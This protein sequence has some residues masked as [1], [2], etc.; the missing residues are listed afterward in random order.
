MKSETQRTLTISVTELSKNTSK[1]INKLPREASQINVMK[2][3]QPVAVI[4]SP[5]SY[6]KLVALIKQK[7]EGQDKIAEILSKFSQNTKATV[8]IADFIGTEQYEAKAELLKSNYLQ[9]DQ[10]I[11]DFINTLEN[12]LLQK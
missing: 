4:L 6:M 2:N 10:M 12:P 7:S 1:Y 9:L 8:N 3:N 5:L 11:N